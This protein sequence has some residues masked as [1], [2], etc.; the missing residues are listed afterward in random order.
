LKNKI[1]THIVPT[2]ELSINGAEAYLVGE[3]NQGVKNITPVLNITRVYSACASI[4]GLRRCLAISTAYAKVRKINSQTQFLKDNPLHVAQLATIHLTYRA[5]MQQLFGVIGLLG[6]VECGVASEDEAARLRLLTPVVKAFSAEKAVA[7]MEDAMTTLGGQGYMEESGF[8][9]A[10]RDCL[11][12]RIWE[13]T[14][15]VLSVELARGAAKPGT[16]AAY[17]AVSSQSLP[18]SSNRRLTSVFSGQSK[19]SQTAPPI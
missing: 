13:G 18:P 12:E 11:V 2:A 10:I 7:A 19:S 16:L 3:L 6:K 4:G 9:R 8:G 5:L 14:T 1:G 15:N 17:H